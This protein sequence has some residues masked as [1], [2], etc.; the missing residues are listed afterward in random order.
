M[1]RLRFMALAL[2]SLQSIFQDAHPLLL[3]GMDVPT[4]KTSF[5]LRRRSR[6]DYLMYQETL[7]RP[8]ARGPAHEHS[9]AHV[10]IPNEEHPSDHLPVWADFEV[11]PQLQ[12]QRN[13]HVQYTH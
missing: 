6:I 9:D 13:I 10:V 8:I 2:F 12:V 5:T 3:G 11:A 1:Q 4:S 7:L